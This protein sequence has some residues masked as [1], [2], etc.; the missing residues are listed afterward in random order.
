MC[1][2]CF[3]LHIGK[4]TGFFTSRVAPIRAKCLLFIVWF[5]VLKTKEPIP[6]DIELV[7][8]FFTPGA[9]IAAGFVSL[10]PCRFPRLSRWI[11]RMRVDE[12]NKNCRDSTYFSGDFAVI[13]E[14]YSE[15]K[16]ISKWNCFSVSFPKISFQL[17]D[18]G[19]HLS[20]F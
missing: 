13:E 20:S 9:W 19:F 17:I 10:P 18:A 2:M 5:H 11:R 12:L 4:F 15:R 16:V 8:S 7:T 14:V 3:L 1:K 6:I